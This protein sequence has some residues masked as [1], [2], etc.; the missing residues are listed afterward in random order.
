MLVTR[1][2]VRGLLQ[3]HGVMAGRRVVLGE[4]LVPASSP[5]HVC[6]AGAPILGDRWSE[7]G[8]AGVR[9][10]DRVILL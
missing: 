8:S 5:F 1:S 10:Q 3:G 2:S 4:G 9:E 6:M 7:S